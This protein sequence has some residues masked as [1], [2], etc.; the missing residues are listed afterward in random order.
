MRTD[1]CSA[2]TVRHARFAIRPGKHLDMVAPTPTPSRPM[3]AFGST[4]AVPAPS[5][6]PRRFVDRLARAWTVR[7]VRAPDSSCA[8]R[9]TCLVFETE[10]LARRVW[11]FPTDWRDLSDTGLEALSEQN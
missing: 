2:R 7:E 4:R 11:H 10:R 9:P 8:P 1:A 5:Q 6:E 3:P